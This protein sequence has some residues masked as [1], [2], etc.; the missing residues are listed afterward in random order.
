MTLLGVALIVAGAL[1]WGSHAQQRLRPA[2]SMPPWRRSLAAV[3]V[4]A[5][6]SWRKSARTAATR[7]AAADT[8][9]AFSAEL[10]TGLPPETAWSRAAAGR[11]FA[12]HSVGAISVAGDV[13]TGLRADAAEHDL[14]VLIALAAV[15]QVSAGAGAGLS[16]A[17]YR[18]GAAA[19]QRERLRRDLAAQMAGP[20]ATARVLALL[21]LVGLLLGS[22]LGGSP[23]AWLLGTPV[24]WVLL[25]FGIALEVVGLL[26]VRRLVAGV[27]K[28]L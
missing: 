8:V 16:D 26:W 4:A 15:W 9:L 7:R 5:R 3:A 23:V 13:P 20:K 10:A 14:A 12:R 27:E 6:R 21:P 28:H 11:D 17:A 2:G 24:G 19:L 18:L 22:G 25:A 1:L